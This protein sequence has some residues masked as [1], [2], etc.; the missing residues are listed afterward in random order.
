MSSADANENAGLLRRHEAEPVLDEDIVRAM[1][2][3]TTSDEL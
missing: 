1:G 3:L 2:S